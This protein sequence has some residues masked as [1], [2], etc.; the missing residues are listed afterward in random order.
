MHG[1]VM[2]GLRDFVVETADR[3]TWRD[4]KSEATDRTSFYLPLKEYPD[5]ELLAAVEAAVET[6]E[7]DHDELLFE[8]GVFLMSQLYET[9]YVYFDD[10]WDALD[11]IE[12]VE[13]AIHESLRARSGPA[14]TPPKLRTKRLNSSTVALEYRSER[15]LTDLAKG[16]IIGLGEQFGEPLEIEQRESMAAG[17][18]RDIFLISRQK[19]VLGGF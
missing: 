15:E 5:E 2:K 12:N 19:D 6:L 1:I 4:I 14:F 7:V 11:A 3:Q 16:L 10:E 17:D 9:Y 18:E 8:F 13:S